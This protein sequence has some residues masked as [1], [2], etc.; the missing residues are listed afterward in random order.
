MLSRM[1]INLNKS[2][3]IPVGAMEN[4]A[5]LALELGC[6]LGSLP[7]TCLGLPLGAKHKS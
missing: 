5:L 7:V 2:S 4:P 1:R 6:N 3:I